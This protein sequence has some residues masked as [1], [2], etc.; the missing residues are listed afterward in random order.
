VRDLHE[1]LSAGFLSKDIVYRAAEG[2]L[3][4]FTWEASGQAYVMVSALP[5]FGERGCILCHTQPQRRA[6][7]GNMTPRVM[8]Q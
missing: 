1:R 6:L 2:G 5:H 3:K 8:Q 4:T 7:I